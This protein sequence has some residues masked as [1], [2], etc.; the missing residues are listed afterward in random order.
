MVMAKLAKIAIK[1]TWIEFE[2]PIV[3]SLE[4]ILYSLAS[5]IFN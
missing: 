4:E 1:A 5:T 3:E 2:G